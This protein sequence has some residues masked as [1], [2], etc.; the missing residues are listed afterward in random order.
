M[1]TA[2]SVIFWSSVLLVA[3]TYVIYPLIIQLLS[4]WFG[5]DTEFPAAS[6]ATSSPSISIILAAHNEAA[7]L[8]RRLDD[9]LL[10]T[11]GKR[12]EILVVSD[13]STDATA[14]I[15]R[16][17][18]NRGVTLIDLESRQGKAAALSL[19]ARMAQNEILVLADV[20][21]TWGTGA[22]DALLAPFADA[23]VGAVGGEL[24]LVAS[25]GVLRGVGAYWRFEKWLRAREARLHSTVGVSGAIAAC[26]R[27][28]FPAI[29]DGTVLDDVYWPLCVVMSGH[30]VIF[31]SRAKAFDQ[32]PASPSHEFRRK[33]RTQAGLFQLIPRLPRAALPS[34]NR[35]WFQLWSHKLLRLAVPWALLAMMATAAALEGFIH[36]TAFWS[37]VIL[38]LVAGL[39]FISETAR[40]AKIVSVASSFILL[41]AAAWWAFWVWVVG[42]VSDSWRKSAYED[43]AAVAPL[44]SRITF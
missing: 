31:E 37:T 7:N 12:V 4:K 28:L 14:A 34:G 23:A 44:E 16:G 5:R 29:P 30:R 9:L 6:T 11:A 39:G 21:Q 1:N 10:G 35:V 22:V 26:R 19:G 25:H 27:C 42:G 2:L 36:R 32:L 40:R 17:F 18:G 24:E 3:Y 15:A 20:R 38:F 13:G 43:G 8:A 41:N 33:V